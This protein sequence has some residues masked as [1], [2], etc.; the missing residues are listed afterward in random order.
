M[1][2]DF[3]LL[4]GR[5]TPD[6]VGT[7][8]PACGENQNYAPWELFE[9]WHCLYFKSNI[10]SFFHIEG[11]HISASTPSDFCRSTRGVS[12]AHFSFP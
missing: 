1:R 11:L 5:D 2:Q 7:S 8:L 10:L 12:T 6:L 9:T 4:E 3:D